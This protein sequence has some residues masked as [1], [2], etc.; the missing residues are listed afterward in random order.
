[1]LMI[2]HEAYGLGVDIDATPVLFDTVPGAREGNIR[3]DSARPE[4]ISYMQ[5]HGYPR[6]F[7]AE[8]WQGSV[9]DGVAFLRQFE[10]IVIH[11]RCPHTFEESRLWSYKKDRL[12]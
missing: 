5:R 7:A 1:R 12:T 9:E 2:E 3:A 10:E 6:I 11:P 8:K 4:T